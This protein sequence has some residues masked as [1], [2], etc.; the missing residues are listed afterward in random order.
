MLVIPR[1]D[2]GVA[3]L[4]RMLRRGPTTFSKRWLKIKR[5]AAEL[6]LTFAPRKAVSAGDVARVL[7]ALHGDDA[8]SYNADAVAAEVTRSQSRGRK[9]FT[10]ESTNSCGQRQK[11]TRARA[12]ES[13]PGRSRGAG[14][15]TQHW[16]WEPYRRFGAPWQRG[17]LPLQCPMIRRPLARS[18]PRQP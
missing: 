11:E 7:Q 15:Q 18:T 9:S 12:R 16:S 1:L 14:V 8:A 10:A 6:Q 5:D 3:E 2:I 13:S 4:A 17:I